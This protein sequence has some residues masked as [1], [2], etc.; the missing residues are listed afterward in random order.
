MAQPGDSPGSEEV[1]GGGGG[2]RIREMERR[3]EEGEE[4]NEKVE[5]REGQTKE[6]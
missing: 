4:E 1:V 2:E 5:K 3:G 6:K